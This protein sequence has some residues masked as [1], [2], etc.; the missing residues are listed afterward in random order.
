MITLFGATGYTGRLI[1]HQLDQVKLPFRIAGRSGEKLGE[2]ASE[3]NSHPSTLTADAAQPATLPPLFRDTKIFIN[4]AGPFT[5]LGEKVIRQAALNGVHY[6]DITN[7]L[8]YVYR[9][10]TYGKL[11]QQNKTVLIPACGFE[12]AL[13]DFG[14]ALLANILPGP[15]REAHIVYHL[16][17]K[18]SSVGTRRSALRSLATSWIVYRGGQWAGQAPGM[19]SRRIHLTSGLMP[20]ISFP[21]SESVTIPTHIDVQAVHTWMVTSPAGRFFAPVFIPLFARILR[22]ILRDP[23]LHLASLN[24]PPTHELRSHDPFEIKVTL[25]N[26]QESRSVS[27]TGKGAYDLTANIIC[28]AAERLMTNPPSTFGCRPPSSLCKPNDFFEVAQSWGV[29]FSEVASD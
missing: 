18:G 24:P 8:G 15:Y 27:I 23:I 14:A 12:V 20:A 19:V 28:F 5:D 11:A 26:P 25:C 22:S 21:S 16:P 13:A 4:C 7:E 9:A 10:Q 3:L 1:A 6:L 2:L 17:G 29:S